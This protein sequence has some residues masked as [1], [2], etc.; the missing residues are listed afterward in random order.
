[1][2]KVKLKS[3]LQFAKR[4]EGNEGEQEGENEGKID[5]DKDGNENV[6]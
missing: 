5:E 4:R 3:F 2:S 6:Y 1:M